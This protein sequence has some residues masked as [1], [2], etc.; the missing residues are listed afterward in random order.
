MHGIITY[1]CFGVRA[2]GTIGFDS[3]VGQSIGQE[4]GRGKE[5]EMEGIKKNIDILVSNL[6]SQSVS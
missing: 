6:V 5:G 4:G 3:F 1:L 2:N